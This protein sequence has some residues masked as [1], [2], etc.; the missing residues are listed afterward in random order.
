[1][2]HE[3]K[4]TTVVEIGLRECL[5][6]KGIHWVKR[7][8]SYV[9]AAGR[10]AYITPDITIEEIAHVI[11]VDGADHL[12]EP[13][14]SKDK[15]RDESI[16]GQGYTV[17]HIQN[18]DLMEPKDLNKF[19]NKIVKR[20]ERHRQNQKEAEEKSKVH[21]QAFLAEQEKAR[22]KAAVARAAEEREEAKKREAR[23]AKKRKEEAERAVKRRKEEAER[24]AAEAQKIEAARQARLEKERQD[25]VKQAVL[26]KELDEAAK[27]EA[28]RKAKEAIIAAEK[29]RKLRI[30]AGIATAII[31]ILAI[32]TANLLIT[33]FKERAE[34]K[35]QGYDIEQISVRSS[36]GFIT[37]R[38]PAAIFIYKS[39]LGM[40][41]HRESLLTDKESNDNSFYLLE[42]GQPF[43]RN[44]TTEVKMIVDNGC[45]AIQVV[46]ACPKIDNP[47]PTFTTLREQDTR[48]ADQKCGTTNYYCLRANQTTG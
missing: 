5:K 42:F 21:N 41:P 6:E 45:K 32:I 36:T 28:E 18:K 2:G 31:L 23:E 37:L 44:T 25:R 3:E 24:K 1:M 20:V 9:N 19:V 7:K 12:R 13:Q 40:Q 46:V 16:M 14:L 10:I 38:E 30:I 47:P 43:S 22:R 35:A 34:R 15:R 11:E 26:Q 33:E 48:F 8:F 17:E 39:I 27:K 29:K 4:T